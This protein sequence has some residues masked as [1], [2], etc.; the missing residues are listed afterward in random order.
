M[1]AGGGDHFTKGDSFPSPSPCHFSHLLEEVEDMTPRMFDSTDGGGS[2][3]IMPK[4]SPW[5]T[6]VQELETRQWLRVGAGGFP[7]ATD[8]ARARRA[9][10]R[11]CAECG[12]E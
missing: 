8:G 5:T 3:R 12:G 7:R 9:A 6:A 1:G 11:R 10:E 4:G 2:P